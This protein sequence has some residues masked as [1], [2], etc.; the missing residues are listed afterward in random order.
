MARGKLTFRET[1]ATRAIKAA[2]RAGLEVT[3]MEVAKDGTIRVL[4][5]PASGHTVEAPQGNSWADA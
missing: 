5:S 4:T 3:G 2:R 1:D